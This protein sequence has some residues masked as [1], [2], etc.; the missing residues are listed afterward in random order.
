VTVGGAA[1]NV[2]SANGGNGVVLSTGATQNRVGG[3]LIGVTAAGTVALGN[4]LDGVRFDGAIG[5]VIGGEAT[6]RN[7]PTGG[8][9]VRTPQGNLISGNAGNRVLIIG[10]TT[11]NMLAGNFIDT[12]ASGNAALGNDSDGVAIVGAH[13]NS[14][15]G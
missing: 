10:K 9:F 11:Q 4:K 13:G 5:N 7:D 1:K 12:T 8:V 6:G 2:V 15:L 14:L 3:N